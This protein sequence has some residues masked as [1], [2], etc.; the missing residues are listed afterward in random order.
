MK[1][2]LV[3]LILLLVV[4]CTKEETQIEPKD[5]VELVPL[6]NE[7]SGWTRSSA[8][9]IAENE[10]Q[11]YDIIDGAGQVYIDNNFVK[12]VRQFYEGDISGAVTI[13]LHIADMNDTVNAKNVYDDQATGNEIPWTN[14]NA[15]VEAR[16][17]LVTGIAVNY[18]ELDFWDDKFYSWI[19]IGDDSDAALDV[20]KLFAL[21][22]SEAIRDTTAQ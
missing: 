18:Y 11:L 9:E 16:Y 10:T 12:F 13:E 20:A 4:F 2:L 21:N 19:Y 22:I 8:M 3:F 15:G 7:I 14:D 17:K 1:K 5:V 6:D